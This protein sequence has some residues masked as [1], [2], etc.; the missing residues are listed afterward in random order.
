MPSPVHYISTRD[1]TRPYSFMDAMLQGLAPNGGLFVPNIIPSLSQTSLET[2]RQPDWRHSLGPLLLGDLLAE[3]TTGDLGQCIKEAIN[4]PIPLV[5]L[6]KNLWLLEVFH[7]PTLAFKDVGARFMARILASVLQKKKIS[8]D[9]LVATSGDTGSAVAHGFY[10]VPNVR[11]HVLY[12]AGRISFLQ[13]QQMATLGGNIFPLRVKGSFDDCQ[14]LVKTALSDTSL[15]ND[16]GLRLSTANSINV[17]R[18]LPQMIYHASGVIELSEK[19]GDI[20]PLLCVP[21]GN[22]GNLVSAIYARARGL[23]IQHFISAT[24]RNTVF[25]DYLDSGSYTPRASLQ[26]FSSAMDVGHPSNFERLQHFFE[27]DIEAMRA[28]ITAIS[29]DDN[30]T[31]ETIRRVYRQHG[32]IADPHTAVGIAA[33]ETLRNNEKRF[34]EHPVIVTATAHPAKF[35]EVIEKALGKEACPA[36][37]P[38]LKLVMSL[39][40]TSRDLSPDYAAFRALL[41]DDAKNQPVSG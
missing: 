4:F 28:S 11:V 22:L 20:P 26:T 9:I 33:A 35:P 37:P 27:N 30:Q 39:P 2:L 18:L 23:P 13:E 21:S 31:L 32:Y 6:E 38:S 34:C 29:V 25:P 36:Q 1:S 41:I 40:C 10:A 17:A 7:G 15:P 16:C 24:N 14:R 5:P 8:M 3:W 19:I 12:P